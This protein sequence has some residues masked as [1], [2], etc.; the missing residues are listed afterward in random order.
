MRMSR[1]SGEY[2][3][4]QLWVPLESEKQPLTWKG[5]QNKSLTDYNWEE[6]FL[7]DFAIHY[8]NAEGHTKFMRFD[9]V[10]D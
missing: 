9:T 7:T 8:S 2:S 3:I 1:Q 4:A 5:L 6:C 10:L